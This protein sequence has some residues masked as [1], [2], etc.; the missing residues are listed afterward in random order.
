MKHSN[1]ISLTELSVD[2]HATI[3]AFNIG[4]VEATR[5]VSLG[6][7]PGTEVSM[8]QNYGWGPLIV[9]VRGTRVALGRGEAA[10]ILVERSTK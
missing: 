5:L 9:T 1:A 4:T 7:T 2:N 6:L 8:S 10:K 3:L